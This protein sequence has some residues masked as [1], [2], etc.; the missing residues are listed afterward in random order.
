MI[1]DLTGLSCNS[2][3]VI[4]D[5]I[6]IEMTIALEKLSDTGLL[7]DTISAES[8]IK[9]EK[10]GQTKSYLLTVNNLNYDKM[11]SYYKSKKT[12]PE[13]EQPIVSGLEQEVHQASTVISSSSSIVFFTPPAN[14]PEVDE[15]TSSEQPTPGKKD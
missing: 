10:N 7:F 5:S 14:Q 13:H 2:I 12:G 8:H 6:E 9:F 11:H 1:H 4:N 15:Q 3:K